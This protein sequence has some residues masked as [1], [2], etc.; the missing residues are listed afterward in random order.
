MLE[1]LEE[2]RKW[3]DRKRIKYQ[4]FVLCLA[5]VRFYL[6]G[7][8][9]LSSE[10]NLVSG[11]EFGAPYIWT[12]CFSFVLF[13]HIIDNIRSAKV[14]FVL[15][16]MFSSLWFI[17]MGSAFYA[18]ANKDPGSMLYSSSLLKLSFFLIAGLQLLQLI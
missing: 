8:V 12:A 11:V 4:A 17:V 6:I 3:T 2:Q 5:F 18:D 14:L 9:E 1:Y 7:M 16:E 10:I 13:G 15:L